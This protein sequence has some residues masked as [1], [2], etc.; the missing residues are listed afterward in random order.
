[1]SRFRNASGI[2]DAMKPIARLVGMSVAAAVGI[3]AS[4]A[5]AEPPDLRRGYEVGARLEVA[6]EG[7]IVERCEIVGGGDVDLGELTGGKEMST[8]FG[9]DC[10]LPFQIDLRSER[11]GLAHAVQPQ[12]E[13]PY[14]GVLAYDL[15]VA[16]PTLQPR[17]ERVVVEGDFSS[18]E[19]IGV[20]S[21]S[22]GEGISAGRGDI[23]LKTRTPPGAGLLAGRYQE[24]LTMTIV[25]RV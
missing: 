11:G 3:A 24:T 10:N 16:V 6:L 25:P 4:A 17:G 14:A 20:R 1:M 7:R 9:L 12:G 22:S 2:V 8:S 15:K 18:M 19:L 5:A 13:G 23:L 21:I